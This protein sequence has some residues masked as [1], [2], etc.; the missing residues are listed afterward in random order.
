MNFRDAFTPLSAQDVHAEAQRR[1]ADGWRYVQLLAVNKEGAVDLVYSYMK[2][3]LLDNLVVP[4]VP[5]DA[6]IASISDVYLEAFVC[7]NEINDLFGVAFDGI[8]IDFM[9]NFYRLSTEKPMTIVS[10]AQLAEREQ[11]RKIAAAKAAQEA[12]KAAAADGAAASAGQPSDA[13]LEAELAGMDPEK[14]AKVRA[15]ME[16]KRAK[17]ASSDGKGN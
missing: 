11:Q 8:V 1:L 17:Q 5:L 6:R 2:D 3:G 14:A 12:Q 15:A 16:A 10:P 7:E 9:G 4:N 13:Q